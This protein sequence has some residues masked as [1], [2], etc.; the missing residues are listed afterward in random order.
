M[1]DNNE[2]RVTSEDITGSKY[3]MTLT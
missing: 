3:F 1:K 2:D